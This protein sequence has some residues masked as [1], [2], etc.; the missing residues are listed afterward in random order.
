[1]HATYLLR[2]SS[3]TVPRAAR[4]LTHIKVDRPRPKRPEGAAAR[5]RR[6]RPARHG[7]SRPRP[8]CLRRPH[9]RNCRRRGDLD[10]ASAVDVVDRRRAREARSNPTSRRGRRGCSRDVGILERKLAATQTARDTDR[11]SCECAESTCQPVQ[12]WTGKRPKMW[13]MSAGRCVQAA[14]GGES[15]CGTGC[16]AP[17]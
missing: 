16:Y 12:Q 9:G 14:R 17:L 15:G 13:E 6:R 10:A 8:R 2:H 11:W 4:P 7:R 1:M 5:H 3:R